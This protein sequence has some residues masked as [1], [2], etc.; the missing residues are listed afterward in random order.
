LYRLEARKQYGTLIAFPPA[1]P[2]FRG[3]PDRPHRPWNIGAA[4]TTQTANKAWTRQAIG[5]MGNGG[6]SMTENNLAG[7]R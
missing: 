2:G 1:L 4:P 6:D 5:Q 7:N 3:E